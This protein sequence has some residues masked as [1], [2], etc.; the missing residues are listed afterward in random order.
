M[1]G[2]SHETQAVSSE[3]ASL[4]LNEAQHPDA[5]SPNA[6]MVDQPDEFVV[7]PTN[8]PTEDD[9]VAIITPESLEGATDDASQPRADD[10][11]F[12]P[13]LPTEGGSV[14]TYRLGR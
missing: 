8:S 10:C 5:P 2:D 9:N 12:S 14:L 13:G 7:E 6:M 11:M 3:I 4:T 1:A